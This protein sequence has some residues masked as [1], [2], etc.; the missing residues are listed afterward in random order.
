M[1]TVYWWN[2]QTKTW[3]LLIEDMET[4][5]AERLCNLIVEAGRPMNEIKVLPPITK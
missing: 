3:V 2:A 5:R 4:W 1:H